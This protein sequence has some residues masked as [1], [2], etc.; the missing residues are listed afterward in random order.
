MEEY[1]SAGTKIHTNWA[2]WFRIETSCTNVAKV[3]EEQCSCF[4][5]KWALESE[6]GAIT[7]SASKFLHIDTIL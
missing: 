1:W 2:K 7:V 5:T 6:K 3:A 4:S